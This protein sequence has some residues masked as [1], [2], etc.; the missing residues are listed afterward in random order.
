MAN[1]DR[2][3]RAGRCETHS[4]QRDLQA[5]NIGAVPGRESPS[6]ASAFGTA[7]TPSPAN[8]PFDSYSFTRWYVISMTLTPFS[9]ELMSYISKTCSSLLMI[10][11]T[12]FIV[13]LPS[14][15]LETVP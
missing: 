10:R 11:D 9:A 12:Y 1:R 7:V 2:I 13:R 3:E 5:W 15:G 14:I 6:T 4:G 8:W